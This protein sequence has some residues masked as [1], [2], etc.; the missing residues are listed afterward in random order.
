MYQGI[1]RQSSLANLFAT[2][3]VNQYPLLHG[4]MEQSIVL[5]VTNQY[6]Q[7][8]WILIWLWFATV[9]SWPARS[10][11]WT[12]FFLW[13]F[14]SIWQKQQQKFNWKVQIRSTVEMQIGVLYIFLGHQWVIEVFSNLKRLW[15]FDV[16]SW[17]G[18]GNLLINSTNWLFSL[19]AAATYSSSNEQSAW[20]EAKGLHCLPNQSNHPILLLQ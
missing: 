2:G 4:I 16:F 17:K 1:S 6:L 12:F 18:E 20:L 14:R 19:I 15:N 7:S 8:Q 3:L 9:L 13:W 10:T 11:G 5:A